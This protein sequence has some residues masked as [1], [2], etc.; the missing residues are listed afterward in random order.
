MTLT[1]VE[2]PGC[3]HDVHRRIQ[4]PLLLELDQAILHGARRKPHPCAPAPGQGFAAGEDHAIESR[5]CTREIDE[6]R[7]AGANLIFDGLAPG[8]V[9]RLG[10]GLLER[11]QAEG[12][13]LPVQR[14]FVL[15]VRIESAHPHAGRAG[16]GVGVHLAQAAG[17]Q[18]LG[19]RP[20]N[21]LASFGCLGDDSA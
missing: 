9:A 15:K 12:H 16:N 10:E 19:P 14:E 7:H 3:H 4:L 21:S 13:Q 11:G 8:L 6:S 1:G 2:N 17:G 5:R 20:K 18:H